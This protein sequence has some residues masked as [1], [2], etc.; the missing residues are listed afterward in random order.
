MN[1]IFQLESNYYF[2]QIANDF[3]TKN[4]FTYEIIFLVPDCLSELRDELLANI[5]FFALGLPA[6]CLSTLTLSNQELTRPAALNFQPLQINYIMTL[7]K[8]S[9]NVCIMICFKQSFLKNG[10]LFQFN[11]EDPVNPLWFLSKDQDFL[12]SPLTFS[13]TITYIFLNKNQ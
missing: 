8:N 3:L 5:F 1:N 9:R 10:V 2:S 13:S 4:L 12:F 7:L 11:Y 6:L